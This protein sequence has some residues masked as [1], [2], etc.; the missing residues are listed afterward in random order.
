MQLTGGEGRF[1]GLRANTG[2]DE[3]LVKA[4]GVRQGFEANGVL[5]YS[6]HAKVI[7]QTPHR[8]HQGVVG[9]GAL[10]GHHLTTIVDM[11]GQVHTLLVAIEPHHG[12]NAV[13]EM[14]P[15]GLHDVVQLMVIGVHAARG[16]FMEFGFPHMGSRF[17]NECHVK[18]AKAVHSVSIAIPK[19]SRQLQAARSS[20][21]YYNTVYFFHTR[22]WWFG[23]SICEFNTERQS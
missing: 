11:G 6:G 1:L 8:Q 12:A 17:V 9:D 4:L 5:L 18:P 23:F 7:G 16:D 15:M 3:P 14:V 20:P 21:H 22:P 2:V 13:A 19:R 10:R